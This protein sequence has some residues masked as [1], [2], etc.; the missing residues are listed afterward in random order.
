MIRAYPAPA[1]PLR[2]RDA[3]PPRLDRQP[4]LPRRALPPGCRARSHGGAA[5]PDAAGPPSAGRPD[6]SR[7]GLARLSLRDPGRLAIGRLCRDADGDRRRRQRDRARQNDDLR[8]VGQGAVRHPPPRAGAAGHAALQGLVG[9]L[10]RLQRDRLWQPL[11][12]G[13]VVARRAQAGLQGDL[14]AAGLR[15]RRPHHGGEP[16]ELLRPG[17]AAADLRALGRPAGALA[18][19]RGLRAALLHR[20][21]PASRCGAARALQPAAQRRP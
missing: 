12:R 20:L 6:R 10:G 2:R 4:A 14:A 9:D 16:G 17:R 8:A 1:Q 3:G 21:G 7:L 15:H 19:G 11:F 18:R 5:R 13:A